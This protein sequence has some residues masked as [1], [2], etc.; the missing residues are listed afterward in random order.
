VE[1]HS[2]IKFLIKLYSVFSREDMPIPLI[3]G[4]SC[5]DLFAG[6]FDFFFVLFGIII[7]SE[8]KGIYSL[9]DIIFQ[10]YLNLNEYLY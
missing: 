1:S 8:K 3:A 2:K 10:P 9:F 4:F 6:F 5:G 7:A